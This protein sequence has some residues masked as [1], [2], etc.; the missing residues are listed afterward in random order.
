MTDQPNEVEDDG[1]EDWGS[2]PDT[3]GCPDGDVFFYPDLGT[4]C[5]DHSAKAVMVAHGTV[6]LLP[7]EGGKWYDVQ[8]YGKPANTRKLRTVQ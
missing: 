5:E 8:D 4:F 3:L 2:Y 1:E 6:W 7:A